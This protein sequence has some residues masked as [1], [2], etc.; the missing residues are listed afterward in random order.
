[1]TRSAKTTVV[2]RL[3]AARERHLRPSQSP[4]QKRGV[5]TQHLAQSP[6]TFLKDAY[7]KANTRYRKHTR[8]SRRETQR[9]GPARQRPTATASP[10]ATAT[11]T[12]NLVAPFSWV[13]IN[14]AV[15]E[16]LLGVPGSNW[17]S[18]S[19]PEHTM[20]QKRANCSPA[21]SRTDD[22]VACGHQL[23]NSLPP[24]AGGG[25]HV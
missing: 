22:S 19:Q 4:H 6:R 14:I 21:T 9:K 2:R 11:A 20:T 15:L 18:G 7:E 5:S 10:T 16:T 8:R 17:S 23:P 12:Q 3:L 13:I 1:M 24:T 25:R